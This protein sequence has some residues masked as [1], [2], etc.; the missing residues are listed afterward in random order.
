MVAS[1][2]PL[3]DVRQL[4]FSYGKGSE[5]RQVLFDV[6][7]TIEPGQVVFVTGPSGCGKTTLLSL[8]GGLR[9]AHDGHLQTLGINLINASTSLQNSVRRQ[10]GFV[11]QLHN[12]LDFLTARQNVRMSLQLIPDLSPEEMDC[13]AGVLLEKVGLQG[14]E[15]AYPSQLSGGQRQRVSIARALAHQ[16]RLILAD[17]PTSAL[18]G[19]TGREIVLLMNELARTQSCSVLMV[20]HDHRITDIA[21]RIIAMD[22]GRIN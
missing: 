9:T 14:R 19:K 6:D 15:D 21:D 20:T 5:A 8:I 10:I 16:P 11:F 12:L 17:E 22:D 18:D 4:N 7:L 2:L 1:S 3:V 13:R